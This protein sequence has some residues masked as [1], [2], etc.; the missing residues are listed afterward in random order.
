MT[1]AECIKASTSIHPIYAMDCIPCCSRLVVSAR[2]WK[3][4]QE[5]MLAHIIKHGKVTREQV[6]EHINGIE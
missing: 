5:A 2:P 1:C 6:L 3:D 4:R